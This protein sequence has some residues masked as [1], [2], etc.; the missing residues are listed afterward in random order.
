[1]GA[2][3]GSSECI[4]MF[5]RTRY[6]TATRERHLLVIAINEGRQNGTERQSEVIEQ[7]SRAASA[8]KR[9]S[10]LDPFL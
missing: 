7:T 10:R 9:F 1:M 3:D 4:V 6:L 5:L 2:H 8:A